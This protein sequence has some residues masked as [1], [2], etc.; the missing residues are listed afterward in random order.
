[1]K[2]KNIILSN[3]NILDLENNNQCKDMIT[4]LHFLLSEF[5]VKFIFLYSKI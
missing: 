2:S 1:M 5:D 4:T 3:E